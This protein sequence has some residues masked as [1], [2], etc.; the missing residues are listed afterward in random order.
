MRKFFIVT[1]VGLVLVG[2]IFL[3]FTLV[4]SDGSIDTNKPAGVTNFPTTDET[5]S[6]QSFPYVDTSLYEEVHE[7]V[8]ALNSVT[9]VDG[10]IFY[11][12]YYYPERAFLLV[13]IQSEPVG[14]ARELAEEDLLKILTVPRDELCKLNIS[15]SVPWLVSERYGG[16]E[17]GLSFCPGSVQLDY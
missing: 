7:G 2:V 17:L 6:Q 11:E 16:R 10:T 1:L 13:S 3:L 15:V 14:V 12:I 5:V 9:N 8:V 4:V